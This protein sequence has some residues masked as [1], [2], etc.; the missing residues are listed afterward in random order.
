MIIKSI[1]FDIG[2]V[3]LDWNPRHLYKNLF[4]DEQEMEYFLTHICN[5]EWNEKQDAGRTIKEA[6]DYLVNKHPE[7]EHHIRAYYDRWEEM[8]PGE[9]KGTVDMLKEL[10]KTNLYTIYALSNWSAETFK[11]ITP[12][13]DF[14]NLFD[15]IVLSGIEKDIKPN[16]GFYRILLDRY[17]L[18]PSETL[19]IDDRVVNIE[20]AEKIGFKT[21]LFT[22][23]EQ[24]RMELNHLRLL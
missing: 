24:L 17:Q 18:N 6:T 7:H 10:K 8:V 11:L 2:M 1:V 4:E 19:F 14:F 5:D 16:P 9:I 22:T 13:F 20:A 23:P 21:I 3:L 12:R 15:G